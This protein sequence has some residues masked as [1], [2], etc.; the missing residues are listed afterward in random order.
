MVR[1]ANLGWHHVTVGPA[2]TDGA[3]YLQSDHFPYLQ[4][5]MMQRMYA[6]LCPEPRDLQGS[7]NLA[8]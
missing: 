1:I 5:C 8:R 3:K 4:P 2:L 6:R 7:V